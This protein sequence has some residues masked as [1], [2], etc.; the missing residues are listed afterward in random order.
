[1]VSPINSKASSFEQLDA[2]HFFL[3]SLNKVRTYAVREKIP[4]IKGWVNARPPYF[5]ATPIQLCKTLQGMVIVTPKMSGSE[6]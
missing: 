6:I 1:M 4:K 2:F 5:R 3:N